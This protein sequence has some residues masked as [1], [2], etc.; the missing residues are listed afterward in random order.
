M[1]IPKIIHYCWLS[2]DE[3][4]EKI[5]ACMASWSEVMPD[6]EI[7]HWGMDS[8]DFDS[9]PFLKDAIMHR[10]WAFVADFIRVYA[11][12]TEGG[13]YLDT[14]VMVF[15]RF[16]ELLN[17]D[18]FIG[19]EKPEIDL[20]KPESAIMGAVKGHSLFKNIIEYYKN[21]REKIN[22]D[23]MKRIC[24]FDSPFKHIYNT[25]N[26]LQLVI[27]P[28]VLIYFLREYGYEYN[29]NEQNLSD[30]IIMYPQPIFVNNVELVSEST[31]AAH[32]YTHS[33][34]STLHFSSKGRGIVFRFCRRFNLH[35]A[36]RLWCQIVETVRNK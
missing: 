5:K 29:S 3:K 24:A 34:V 19:L 2:N 14:D 35:K 6:Y 8:Y 18:V 30:G 21:L 1:S 7:R 28:D 12:Y 9:V 32:L 11:L 20:Y 26:E 15:R 33:W 4:P 13:I 10:K 23:V 17:T 25:N 22:D 16:D 27:A 31:F 36:Y